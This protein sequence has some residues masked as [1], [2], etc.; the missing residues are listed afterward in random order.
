VASLQRALLSGRA[1]LRAEMFVSKIVVRDGR[2]T[3]V[4]YI[5][6]DGE[7]RTETAAHVILAA[8]GLET[9]RLLLLSGFDH[10]LIGR[11]VMFHFQS[12]VLGEMS[13][14]IHG[15]KGRSVT[16]VHDDFIVPDAAS[17]AAARDAGLPWFKGGMVEHASPA[18]PVMEA[19]FSPWGNAHKDVMRASSMREHLLGFCMQGED[20]PQMTNRVDLDPSVRDVRGFPAL[21]VTYRPHRH[22]QVASGYYGTR[23][24][25]CLRSAG[26]KWAFTYTSPGPIDP[27]PISRHVAG[28]T[29]MG[30]DP[31]TSV[32]DAWGR[33]HSVPNLV[34]ADS[35]LFPTGAG[36]GPTLTL[37]ALAVRNMRALSGQGT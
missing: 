9:P 26:A 30:Q 17:L 8:G 28:T 20:L 6:P 4:E 27:I 11:N 19:K 10:P 12:Y 16:H 2:A 3:G 14:R 29:R 1:E 15:H 35:S 25:D 23:M 31:S 34:V 21:R 36:Y 18:H 37:V 7:T 24:E 22:E 33:V 13:M 32:C 5:G